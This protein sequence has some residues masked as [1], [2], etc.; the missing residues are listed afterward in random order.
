MRLTDKFDA[1]GQA[2]LAT[3]LL[4]RRGLVAYMAGQI[5]AEKFANAI[6]REW[7]SMPVVSGPQKGRSYY[8]GDGLN[9]SGVSVDAFM[10]AVKAVKEFAPPGKPTDLQAPKATPEA[11]A[12]KRG[13]LAII[14]AAIVALFRRRK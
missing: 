8:A 11:C 7:A 12:P 6:A 1:D 14:I 13:W 10:A 2:R 3:A 5:T 9:K 4:R